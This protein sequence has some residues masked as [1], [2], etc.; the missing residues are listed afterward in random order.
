MY[1]VEQVNR[2]VSLLSIEEIG[3]LT[4]DEIRALSME[5]PGHPGQR[6]FMLSLEYFRSPDHMAGITH[7]LMAR[8]VKADE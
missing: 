7:A 4:D 6:G 8:L 2:R 5:R 3:G 1:S